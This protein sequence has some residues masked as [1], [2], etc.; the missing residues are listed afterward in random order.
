MKKPQSQPAGP[1]QT[2]PPEVSPQIDETAGSEGGGG[3][4]GYGQNPQRHADR[5]ARG[6]GPQ[7]PPE[8]SRQRSHRSNSEAEG[9]SRPAP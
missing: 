3:R 8:E 6:Q 9:G 2:S 7:H 5:N 1:T 4:V